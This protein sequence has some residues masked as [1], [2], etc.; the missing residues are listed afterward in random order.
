[1]TNSIHVAVLDADVPCLSVY[2]ERGLYSSQFRTLLQAAATRL[3]QNAD[4]TLQHGPLA[5]HITAFDAVGRTLPP[6]HSLR[7]S[8]KTTTEPHA[9]GPLGLIDAILITGSAS[10][11]YEDL[12]WIHELQ[13]FIQIV[14]A[15]YPHVKIFGSC[16][17][18]QII[19]QALL[20]KDQ[21]SPES[22]F[23]VLHDQAGFEMG[24]QPISLDPE[25]TARFPPLARA[26]QL[27]PFRIQL[28]HG[29][30]VAPTPEAVAAASA[31]GKSDVSLPAPWCNIGSSAQCAIQG[32]YNPGRVLTYQGH[33]EF[34][35]F[36]NGELSQEFGRRA[37]WPVEIVAGYL[38][39]IN[40][41]LVPGLEDD[42][43]SKAAAEAV[44][45]FFAG[46]DLKGQGVG[47]ALPGS[48]LLTPPLG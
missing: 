28:V 34:D 25:F 33:F 2:K 36:V 26:S 15:D 16:F 3:N 44:L 12:P 18:H 31:A 6:L 32:L 39:L 10:S 46:K 45:L 17:G 5:V 48:G 47:L 13:A 11:A 21:T 22:S 38:E 8:P 1:M 43:D 9:G 29:D 40:R 37:N 27:N 20:S 23:H 7:N 30:R 42:D 4:T 14:H 41:S 35:T 24:I 19:A